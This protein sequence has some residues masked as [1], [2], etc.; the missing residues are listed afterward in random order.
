MQGLLENNS[1]HVGYCTVCKTHE[2][3]IVY[4]DD[5]D[6]LCHDCQ[7]RILG[8]IT[9]ASDRIWSEVYENLFN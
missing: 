6:S 9:R 4:T 2:K 7:K 5:K 8:V 1:E 3:I